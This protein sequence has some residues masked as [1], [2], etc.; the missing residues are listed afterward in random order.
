MLRFDGQGY[1]DAELGMDVVGLRSHLAEARD[2]ARLMQAQPGIERVGTFGARFGGALAALVADQLD[3]AYLGA[4]EPMVKGT[5]FLRDLFRRQVLSEIVERGGEGGGAAEFDELVKSSPLPVVV[6]F[7]A[8][9]CGP[10]RMVA[11][12][13][14]KLAQARAGQIVVAKLDTEAVPE[15][16]ARYGIRSIP[17]F[18]R[19]DR[20]A[21]VRRASGAMQATALASAL[22]L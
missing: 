5:R 22:G 12:E 2:A 21:E 4:V 20:G 13:L 17:T 11:P 18:I 19:F 8:A 15:V 1:G 9:W 10:C 3:L 14:E 6:D 16:A 7:W